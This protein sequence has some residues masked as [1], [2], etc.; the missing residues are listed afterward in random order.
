MLIL[1]VGSQ[2]FN[3]VELNNSRAS[4]LVKGLV[5][6]E[7]TV[8]VA[9]SG[10]NYFTNGTN[11]A[12]FNVVKKS[13]VIQINCSSEIL[14]DEFNNITVVVVNGTGFVN[15]LLVLRCLMMLS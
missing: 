15:I 4:V 12:K 13:P 11:S 9:Y 7:N 14:F 1:P 2:V 6:G 5:L 10:D 3:D 8:N